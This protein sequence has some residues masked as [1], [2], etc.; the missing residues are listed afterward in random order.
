MCGRFS[1]SG[2]IDFY[3][4]YFGADAVVD[5]LEPSWNVAPTDPV[6]VVSERDGARSLQTMKWGLVPHWAKDL[7]AMQINARSETAA[8]TPAFRD[9][10]A[11]KRCLIPADGFYEWETTDAGRIPHW[12]FRA[13]GYPVGFA[14]LWA[15]RQV[16][17]GEWVRTCAILTTESQGVVAPLHDRMPIA[18]APEQWSS[19]L[20]RDLT[21]ADA[22][23]SLLVRI[24]DDLWIEREVSKKVNSVRNNGPGLLDPP[25]QLRLI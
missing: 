9:S 22:A 20:D 14:G 24:D 11:R 7:K 10:F 12:I 25:D 18:L 3:A 15:T 4:D 19:W 21:D 17:E 13:D 8:T 1:L 2:D 6:Y 16:E 23:H 5:Q